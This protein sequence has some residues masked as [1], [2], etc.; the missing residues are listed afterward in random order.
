[1]RLDP[2][3]QPWMSE[4]AVSRLFGAFPEGELRFVGG[5]VRNALWGEA[6]GDVDLSTPLDPGAV[7]KLLKKHG[8]KYAPT[9]IDHGTVTAVLDKKTF[10]ITSLRK[11]VETDGRRAVVAFTT[12]WRDDAF[13]RDLTVNALYAD[14]SGTVFDPSG[15]GLEDIA[16]HNFRF[17]GEAADRVREDY[18]RILRFFRFIAWYGENRKIDHAGLK[19]CRE[20]RDG[21]KTLSAERIW[22]EIKKLLSAPDPTRSVRIMLTNEILETVLPE[23][24]NLDGLDLMVELEKREGLAPDP[25]LRLAAMSAREPLP[26]A[27]LCKRMKMS[28]NETKR[29]RGWA[30]DGTDIDPFR[31]EVECQKAIYKAGNTIIRDRALLRAAGECDPIK[32]KK[33]MGLAELAV[34]WERPEFPLK[35]KDLKKAGVKS[36]PEMG[37]ILKALEALW[38]RSG[39]T[40]DKDKLLL[41]LTL[42]KGGKS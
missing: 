11:D 24:S 4:P 32:S 12:D 2:E 17:V 36:G 26:I 19:A 8:I 10:E 37:R 35:G 16:D 20:N 18:L 9:G 27:L 6:I 29:L 25:L 15:Q 22:M 38:L 7:T 1:M 13:R 42:I 39:F 14:R 30:E 40:A 31:D 28:S 5:C 34:N 3:K 21:I 41:A 23:A 33:W